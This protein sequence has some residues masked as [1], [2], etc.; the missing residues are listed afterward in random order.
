M[1]IRAV[2]D[3]SVLILGLM[4]GRGSEAT[5]VNAWLDGS[6]ALVTSLCLV[7]ELVHVLSSSDLQARLPLSGGELAMLV[8]GLLCRADV[9]LGH[10]RVTGI[11]HD[12]KHDAIL[13]CAAEGNVDFIVTS[14]QG[15]SALVR[16]EGFRA[17][18]A[19]Q[20]V[21]MVHAYDGGAE[22]GLDSEHRALPLLA[23]RIRGSSDTGGSGEVRG[24]GL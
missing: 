19:D 12:P 4:S 15:L 24:E 21:A 17:V 22:A 3:S 23:F 16:H 1:V 6:Y 11:M 2:L 5:V 13:A 14:D 9:T 20:F 8:S 7:E 18:T 10:L